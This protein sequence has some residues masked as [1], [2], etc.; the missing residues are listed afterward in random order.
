MGLDQYLCRTS[1]KNFD[2]IIEAKKL[3]DEF[4][5]RFEKLY[6]EKYKAKFDALPK[7]EYGYVYQE[8]LTEEQ[9]VVLSDLQNQYWADARAIAS[10][11]NIRL[12]EFGEPIADEVSVDEIGYWRKDW[13]L[14]DY[15]ISN[16]WEDKENDNVVNIPLTKENVEQIIKWCS[17]GDN[18]MYNDYT[19]ET[20]KEALNAI[21]QGDVIYYHPWY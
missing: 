7:D 9:K 14:H 19:E 3:R 12:D 8:N 6:D 1:K 13:E 15:I 18:S 2:A 21:K 4:N 10:E 5:S 11:M 20:F 16:F 17:S